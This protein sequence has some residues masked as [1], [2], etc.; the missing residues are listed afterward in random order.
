VLRAA[1][2]TE[3]HAKASIV[4]SAPPRSLTTSIQCAPA[5][6]N[7]C[8]NSVWN[9]VG[10]RA[11][12]HAL[13]VAIPGWPSM[14]ILMIPWEALLCPISQIYEPERVSLRM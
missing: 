6:A 13:I 4:I 5:S 7:S 12:P 10:A 1:Q 3:T 11:F 9:D 8:S 14:L 2:L